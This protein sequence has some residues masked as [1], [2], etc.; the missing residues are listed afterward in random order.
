MRVLS[1]SVLLRVRRRDLVWPLLVGLL[2]WA[3]V[4]SGAGLGAWQDNDKREQ[5][6]G[7]RALFPK[8]GAEKS[9]VCDCAGRAAAPAAQHNHE[10]RA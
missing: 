9:L 2:V 6:I 3:G 1:L 10:L 5:T 8:Q 4:E 7:G